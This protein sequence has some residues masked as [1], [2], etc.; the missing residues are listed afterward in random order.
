MTNRHP[1]DKTKAV[2]IAAVVTS[3]LFMLG[4][5][6]FGLTLAVRDR[7]QIGSD[8][9]KMMA[10]YLLQDSAYELRRTMSALRLCNEVESAEELSR[11]GLVHAVRAETALECHTDDWADSR[12]KEAFLNDIAT[13]LHTYSPQKTI[14]ISDKLY[15]YSAEFYRAVTEK[16]EFVYNGELIEG[17]QKHPDVEITDGDIDA[18]QK[19]V[20]EALETEKTQYVGAWDGHIEFNIERDGKSGYAVVCGDKIIEFAYSRGNDSAPSDKETAKSVAVKTAE[21]CGYDN[22]TVKW[23]DVTG[24]STS[25]LMCKSY[26]G[27]LACDD[28]ATAVV[29]NGNVVAFSAGSCDGEHKN[30]PSAK[31][32]EGEARRAVKNADEGTLVVRKKDGRE[33]ICYEYRLE[34]ED[35]VHYVYVCAESGK[36]IEVK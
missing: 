25:V 7:R 8:S 5:L 29:V 22:L 28:Y 19:L 1:I 32:S 12:D 36:Q 33:R 4:G 9:G 14:E 31:K 35:G 13:V 11:T 34:L 24:S 3:L 17:E 15:E 16:S 18:A 6:A 30:I 26:D 2:I 10:G 23:C 21:R 27:A 20:S